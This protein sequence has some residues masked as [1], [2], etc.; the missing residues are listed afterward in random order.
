MNSITESLLRG[1]ELGMKWRGN[2]DDL[3]ERLAQR[4]ERGDAAAAA[5]SKAGADAAREDDTLRLKYGAEGLDLDQLRAA[6]SMRGSADMADQALGAGASKAV[7]MQGA[8]V[9]AAADKSMASFAD[10]VSDKR[11]AE[12]RKMNA[13]AG[14]DERYQQF[15]PQGKD[16]NR[17]PAIKLALNELDLADKADLEDPEAVERG[18][19]WYKPWF[20]E[21]P[22]LSEKQGKER[23]ERDV[24]RGQLRSSA[25]SEAGLGERLAG[26]DG[27][28]HTYADG[29]VADW[30]GKAWVKRR[31]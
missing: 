21:K 1:A 30:N 26:G 4:K 22:E 8:P 31:K 13:E 28:T 9:V 5:K 14:R 3:A 20:L 18:K 27:T 15:P 16:P 24:Q 29:T 23:A 2:R 19:R 10:R 25:M 17:V 11:Q 12:I 6:D 7:G